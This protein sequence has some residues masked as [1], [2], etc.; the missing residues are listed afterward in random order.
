M[1]SV[2]AVLL[3][4]LWSAGAWADPPAAPV[5]DEKAQCLKQCTGAPR[6]ATGPAL[7]TCLRRCESVAPAP[8]PEAA[9]PDAGR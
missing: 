7:L 6:D 3:G 9:L 2:H 4:V 1:R 8:A 5:V